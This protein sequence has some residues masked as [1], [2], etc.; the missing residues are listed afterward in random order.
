[1]PVRTTYLGRIDS[2]NLWHW[3]FGTATIKAYLNQ[4]Q[5]N[6]LSS[7]GTDGIKGSN[8]KRIQPSIVT[9]IVVGWRVGLGFLLGTCSVVGLLI[10]PNF[11]QLNVYGISSILIGIPI[12]SILIAYLYGKS[13][14]LPMC[15]IDELSKDKRYTVSLCTNERLREAD[16]MT[17]HSFG[18][19]FIPADR[20]E[21]W[22]MKNNEGFIA[23]TNEDNELCACF[24]IIGLSRSFVD[25]FIV[26]K[27]TEHEIDSRI[28]LSF[29]EMKRESRTYISGVV[30]KDPHSLLAGKRVNVMIWVMLK[31]IQ[32]VFGLGKVRTFYAVALNKES[33]KLLY[34]MKFELCCDKSSRRDGHNLYRIDLDRK[35][36]EALIMQ[37]GD[38]S[39]MVTFNW[40]L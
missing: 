31:Y 11:V 16:E 24:V 6:C 26:G 7:G 29:D 9:R 14:Q 20:I 33:E 25:Q 17:R 21:Q 35:K 39:K 34:A 13:K 10:S 19:S 37:F 40:G 18:N 22:R 15:I 36:W 27:V 5:E 32:K 8:M 4:D 3:W 38:Y 28:V 12:A 1:M 30:V 2:Q 23:L